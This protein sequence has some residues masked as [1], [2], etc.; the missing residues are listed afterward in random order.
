MKSK[1][2]IFIRAEIICLI[3]DRRES[4]RKEGGVGDRTQH[5]FYKRTSAELRKLT[6]GSEHHC[7]LCPRRRLAAN[8]EF[9]IPVA[10][11]SCPVTWASGCSF[12]SSLWSSVK[13]IRRVKWFLWSDFFSG[14]GWINWAWF[15]QSCSGSD[16]QA[17]ISKVD[18][19]LNIR[20]RTSSV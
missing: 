9:L 10:F 8:S 6:R 17:S 7:Q 5:S 11:L 20:L 15:P 19:V 4:I 2:S 12:L 13:S 16:L 18:T 1:R 14:R 3:R